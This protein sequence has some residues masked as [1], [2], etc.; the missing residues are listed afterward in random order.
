MSSFALRAIFRDFKYC[1][2]VVL[3]LIFIIYGCFAEMRV[4]G[5]STYVSPLVFLLNVHY[6]FQWGAL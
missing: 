3:V 2:S 6:T 4:H 1:I 5:A